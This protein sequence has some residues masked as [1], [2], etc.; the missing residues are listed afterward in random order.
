MD[1][2]TRII[3]SLGKRIFEEVSLRQVSIDAKMPYTTTHR[4]ISANK[5]LFSIKAISNIK[6]CSLNKEDDITKHYLIISERKKQAEFLNKKPEYKLLTR[7]LP[8]GRFSAV[9][10]G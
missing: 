5:G 2:L 6:L 7:D 9:L 8:A 10:F 4:T 1:N 3:N